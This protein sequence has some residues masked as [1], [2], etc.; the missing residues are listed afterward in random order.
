MKC[1][2]IIQLL[3]LLILELMLD[4]CIFDQYPDRK[5]YTLRVELVDSLGEQ[6][7]DSIASLYGVGCFVN[8]IYRETI[9]K[10]SD[11]KYRYAFLGEDDVTFVALAC[12]NPDEYLMTP[13]RDGM[14]I[15]NRWL[16]MNMPVGQNA[17]DA[18]PVFYGSVNTHISGTQNENVCVKMQDVRAQVR[19]VAYNMLAK[20]GVDNYR[21]VLERCSTGLAYDGSSCGEIADYDLAGK[22]SSDG[23]YRTESRHLLPSSEGLRVR[24]YKGDGKMLFETDKDSQGNTLLL[25]P[26]TNNVIMIQFGYTTD[27]TIKVVPFEEVGNE[28]VFP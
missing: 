18:S 14:A 8:G 24:I 28:T 3:V 20:F 22:L 11:G 13:P 15:Q 4:S 5:Q 6:L 25:R 16:Q 2:R 26:G 12:E 23:N 10:E 17:P 7:S 27:A 19:I 1:N 9:S 21:F